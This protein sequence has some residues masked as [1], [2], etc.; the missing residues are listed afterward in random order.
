MMLDDQAPKVINQPTERDVIPLPQASFSGKLSA[1]RRAMT[2]SLIGASAVLG[3]SNEA[4]AAQQVEPDTNNISVMQDDSPRLALKSDSLENAKF[5]ELLAPLEKTTGVE[6]TYEKISGH[7]RTNT[8]SLNRTEEV[9]DDTLDENR[10]ASEEVDE[11]RLENR[12]LR[13]KIEKLLDDKVSLDA[14]IAEVAEENEDLTR[15]NHLLQRENKRLTERNQSLEDPL[16]QHRRFVRLI[17]DPYVTEHP[18]REGLYHGP[19]PEPAPPALPVRKLMTVEEI[20][21]GFENTDLIHDGRLAQRIARLIHDYHAAD[22]SRERWPF[23]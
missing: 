21:K 17:T 20:M 3:S 18:I 12:E 4:S 22:R 15:Q 8:F 5:G 7:F 14:K 23:R 16:R 11:L 13:E 9:V 10:V 1:L 6:F 2:V 19:A